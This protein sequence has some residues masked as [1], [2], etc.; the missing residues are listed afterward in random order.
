MKSTPE[1]RPCR[2][3]TKP[4]IS[5]QPGATCQGQR[6]T[7]LAQASPRIGN[8]EKAIR[9]HLSL[10]ERLSVVDDFYRNFMGGRCYA[11]FRMEVNAAIKH[12]VL[13]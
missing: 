7:I 6:A 12:G 5:R 1:T 2:S 10:A 3:R 13:Q 11:A 4:S 8:S 9:Q